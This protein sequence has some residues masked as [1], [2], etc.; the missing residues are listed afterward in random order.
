MAKT[1]KLDNLPAAFPNLPLALFDPKRQKTYV[2]SKLQHLGSGSDN[3]ISFPEQ[4]HISETHV[5]IMPDGD[6]RYLVEDLKSTNGTFINHR[7]II[8]SYLSPGDTLTLGNYH[9]IVI[10]PAQDDQT[11][12]VEAIHRELGIILHSDQLKKVYDQA[13]VFA[14]TSENI[15]IFGE[16]GTGKDVLAKFIHHI[17][18]RNKKPYI[19]VNMSALPENLVELELFGAKKGSYT[20]AVSDTAGLMEQAEEGTFFLDEIGDLPLHLQPKLLRALENREVRRIGESKV[21][22]LACRFVFATHKD[23]KS[24]V[25][26]GTF[27]EDLYHRMTVL[28]LTL[29]SLREMKESVIAIAE[30]LI[31]RPYVLSQDAQEKLSTLS[32]PGNIR[33]LKN[34]ITRARVLA[35]ADKRTEI[36]ADDLVVV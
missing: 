12:E 9:L 4:K 6:G 2:I 35:H 30:H 27:R 25:S 36:H 34:L 26:E 23:L 10:Q 20:G 24:A 16:T 19:S 18:T 14:Q 8:K 33:E 1:V 28:P 17:R 5:R 13:A 32:F 31:P 21:R 3:D 29:P 15:C 22:A 11:P 7:P